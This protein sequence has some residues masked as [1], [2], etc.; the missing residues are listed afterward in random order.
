MRIYLVVNVSQIVQYKKQ[1]RGQKKEE[2]KP[3]EV[4]GEEEW[5]VERILNK[6]KVRGIE[7]YLVQ[8]KGF[9]A[10]HDTQKKEEDLVNAREA[11]DEFERKISTEVRRQEGVGKWNHRIKKDKWI[12]LLG[13]YMAKLLY[14]WDNGNFE[15]EYLRKLK[16]N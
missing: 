15:K 7:K 13:R 9:T 4:N 12:E 2:A 3:I 1:V 16:K 10:E 14:G 11:V 8:W 6:R 5:K